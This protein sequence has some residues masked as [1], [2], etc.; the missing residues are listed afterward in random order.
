MYRNLFLSFILI[1]FL[2]P[3]ATA[4][5]GASGL[6][7]PRFVSLG[8]DR[9]RMRSG[10]GKQYPIRWEYHRAG[11]PLEVI[12]EYD[13]WRQVR[14]WE[15]ETGWMHRSLL[16]GRRQAIFVAPGAAL[17]RKPRLSAPVIARPER[18]VIARLDKCGAD[19]CRLTVGDFR[20]W[21]PKADIWGVYAAEIRK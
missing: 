15:G 7:L 18:G 6:P 14:D 16:S 21:T 12:A 13:N 19:W 10:P 2:A 3:A 9:A 20:G 11:M 4:L 17:R 1:M 5:T 8:S